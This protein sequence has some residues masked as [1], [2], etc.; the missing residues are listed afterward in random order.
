MA[1]KHNRRRVRPRSRQHKKND[2]DAISSPYYDLDS[3]SLIGYSSDYSSTSSSTSSTKSVTKHLLSSNASIS[4]H[5]WQNRYTAWQN[6][7]AA[8]RREALKIEEH[9]LK[10]YGGEP[11]DD[12]GLCFKME[13]AFEGMDW[14]DSMN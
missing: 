13:E 7:E 14:V 10:V 2:I 8:Q 9:Q 5:H 6:R 4:A 3:A 12:V 1:H 11:G